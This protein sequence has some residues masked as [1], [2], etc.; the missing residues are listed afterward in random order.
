MIRHARTEP[1]LRTD[2]SGGAAGQ[3]AKCRQLGLVVA[4]GEG[5][6]LVP[7][8]REVDG[9]G[10]NRIAARATSSLSLR[11]RGCMSC[12]IAVTSFWR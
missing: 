2:R 12:R 9:E 10:R 4:S 8:G 7:G 6:G 5:G 11:L 1:R 3:Q